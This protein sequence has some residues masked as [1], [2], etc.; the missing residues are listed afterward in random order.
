MVSKTC[1]LR[2]VR[3]FGASAADARSK[4]LITTSSPIRVMF[5]EAK[6][7][8]MHRYYNHCFHQISKNKSLII[9]QGN[10]E[11]MRKSCRGHRVERERAGLAELL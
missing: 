1:K 8:E 3:G 5:S 9:F 7:L 10:E 11:R 4:E 6:E 2:R